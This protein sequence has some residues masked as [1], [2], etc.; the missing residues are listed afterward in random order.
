V[1]EYW[2]V[3]P[4]DRSVGLA[5][6]ASCHRRGTRHRATGLAAGRRVHRLRAFPR[7]SVRTHV[8]SA[9]GLTVASPAVST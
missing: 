1:P 5:F 6:R 8:V 3:N 7:R 4:D 9:C 2:V